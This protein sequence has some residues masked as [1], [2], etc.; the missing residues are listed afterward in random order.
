[1]T[2]R[3]GDPSWPSGWH[4]SRPSTPGG[5]RR[6]PGWVHQATAISEAGLV[7]EPGPST[8]APFPRRAEGDQVPSA[9]GPAW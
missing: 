4:R 2:P 6:P 1:V 7:G 9:P 8:R 5:G 3:Q